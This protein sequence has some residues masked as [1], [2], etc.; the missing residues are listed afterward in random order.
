M[1]YTNLLN[2]LEQASLFDLH[3]LR[4]AIGKELDNPDKIRVLKRMLHIDMEL[5]YFDY[6]KNRLLKDRVLG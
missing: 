6:T 2:E 5:S 3:R 1:N 4:V